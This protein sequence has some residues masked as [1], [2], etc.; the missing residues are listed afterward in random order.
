MKQDF[1]TFARVMALSVL[2]GSMANVAHAKKP[3]STGESKPTESE[4]AKPNDSKSTGF[5]REHQRVIAEYY[6]PQ[7]TKSHCPPGLAKK[8]NGCLPPGQAKKWQK[9]QPLP[10]DLQYQ[11]L[12]K[13]LSRRLPAPPPNHRFVQ[14]ANDVLMIAIGTGMVI[15]AI[16]N[17]MR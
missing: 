8:N 14:V 13:E 15:D 4:A 2:L 5:T 7:K 6:G 10:T 16:E 17:I 1:K 12:P 3:G 11:D 9:G